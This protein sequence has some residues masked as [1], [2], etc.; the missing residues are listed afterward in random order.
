MRDS[1]RKGNANCSGFDHGAK[2][3]MK[4]KTVLLV[5]AFGNEASFVVLN[6][7]IRF[8]FNMKYPFT[9]DNVHRG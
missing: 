2:S 8:M 5:K 1:N 9:T 3:F 4:V 7:S 6:S